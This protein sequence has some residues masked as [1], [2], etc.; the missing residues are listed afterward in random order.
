MGGFI[1][2]HPDDITPEMILKMRSQYGGWTREALAAMGVPWPPK[3]GWRS[4]LERLHRIGR[5]RKLVRPTDLFSQSD[6][7]SEAKEDVA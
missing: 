7:F 5:P 6:L 3:K 2:N 4:E 1:L